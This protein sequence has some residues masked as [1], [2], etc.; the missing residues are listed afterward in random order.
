MKNEEIEE[1]L[2]VSQENYRRY[3][4]VW[5]RVSKIHTLSRE[6]FIKKPIGLFK[7]RCPKC[8]VKLRTEIVPFLISSEV[9]YRH[10][11]CL[12]CDYEYVNYV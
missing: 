5:K 3:L 2:K 12:K 4:E 9:A 11:T 8:K 7:N 6:E 10:Y 1:A